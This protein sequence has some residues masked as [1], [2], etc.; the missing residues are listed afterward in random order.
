MARG[1]NPSRPSCFCSTPTRS[2]AVVTLDGY[3]ERYMVGAGVEFEFPA[4]NFMDANPLVN[5][6]THTS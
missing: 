4:N 3:N 1:T 6:P 5:R 2:A